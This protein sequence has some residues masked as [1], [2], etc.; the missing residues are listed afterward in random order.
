MADIPEDRPTPGDAGEAPDV[1][2]DHV[3][4][5]DLAGA[6]D[7]QQGRIPSQAGELRRL[8]EGH[9]IMETHVDGE[10]AKRRVVRYIAS[11]AFGDVYET[12]T[13][14]T[15]IPEAMKT[16]TL[17]NVNTGQP[18]SDEERI[19]KLRP[20]LV[21]AHVMLDL[22]HHPN[23]AGIRAAFQIN[24]DFYFF[25]DLV[26]GGCTLK[27]IL[28]RQ[29]TK[30][31]Q[32]DQATLVAL[33]MARGL[34]HMHDLNY[35]HWDVKPDNVLVDV[36][37]AGSIT[38]V[39][40]TDFGQGY[41]PPYSSPETNT[42]YIKAK[43]KASGLTPESFTSA[44][45]N[46]PGTRTTFAA[47][48]VSQLHGELRVAAAS[49]D[50]WSLAVV[51]IEMQSGRRV[52]S[53]ADVASAN[54]HVKAQD[55]ALRCL[56]DDASNRPTMRTV[57][58]E[59]A[60]LVV[61]APDGGYDATSAPQLGHDTVADDDLVSMHMNIGNAFY[62]LTASSEEDFDWA[63]EHIET[64]RQL[65]E[66]LHGEETTQAASALHNLADLLSA[67]VGSRARS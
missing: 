37:R 54:L 23:L 27:A 38:I 19:R 14:D 12:A 51:W 11:G 6:E 50:Q 31:L 57:V 61:D 48:R 30:T 42:Y 35:R 44:V 41:T 1:E 43:T 21:E 3:R 55:V 63:K 52:T 17:T 39:K 22:G 2:R 26:P 34:A 62:M 59:L 64:A 53:A 47:T 16:V 60:L 28:E 13:N 58:E 15:N 49:Q 4:G 24:N 36:D 40:L 45:T 29:P 33:K 25:E 46:K 20:H 66:N 32:Q 8:Q 9:Q 56:A 10:N 18:L 65:V 5:A 7:S 67:Q